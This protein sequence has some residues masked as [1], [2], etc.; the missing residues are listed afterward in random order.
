[1][2]ENIRLTPLQW[3]QI[4]DRF[5]EEEKVTIQG[6]VSGEA[7]CP[8]ITFLDSDMLGGTL[9]NKLKDALTEAK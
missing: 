8:P 4:R 5:T 2:S 7:I 9:A 6:A 1:M 3:A